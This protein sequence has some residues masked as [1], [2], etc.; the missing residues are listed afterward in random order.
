[1]ATLLLPSGGKAQRFGGIMKELLPIDIRG[2]TLLENAILTG[3]KYFDIS[4]IVLITTEEKEPWHRKI[5]SQYP[6]EY[7]RQQRAE[8]WGAIQDGLVDDDMV[9]LLPDTVLSLVKKHKVVQQTP[10]M[11]GVF[12]TDEPERFSTVVN[13][14]IQTKQPHGIFAWGAMYWSREVSHFLDEVDAGHYDEAFNKVLE[15]YQSSTFQIQDYKDLGDVQH[16]FEYIKSLQ[17]HT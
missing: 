13:G 2:T 5:V 11:L 14:K 8:L 7:R 1:M 3:R 10:M 12:I 6:V 4:K 17:S 16:Y 15:Q 9:L